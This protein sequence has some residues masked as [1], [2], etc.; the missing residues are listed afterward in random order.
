M[1]KIVA[2]AA[3]G[4]LA[5]AIGGCAEEEPPT[6][7]EYMQQNGWCTSEEAMSYLEDMTGL[8][9]ALSEASGNTDLML[10]NYSSMEYYKNR[11]EEELTDAEKIEP[12]KG[13]EE[14]Y[15]Y[16]MDSA[17]AFLDSVDYCVAYL[18]A[19]DQTVAASA[20]ASFIE[21]IIDVNDTASKASDEIDN[22][23]VEYSKL[24]DEWEEKYGGDNQDA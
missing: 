12:P 9:D 24:H 6:F 14:A 17:N 15:E 22:F 16:T 7:D 1:R 20:E 5:L 2:V 4:A 18:A 11:V 19:D 23:S 10:A 21:N 8:L 3:A 13:F